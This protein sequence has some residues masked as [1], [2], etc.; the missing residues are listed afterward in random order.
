[1]FGKIKIW[2]GTCT[3]VPVN[4]MKKKT[5]YDYFITSE[6][7]VMVF[8]LC[9]STVE[10]QRN[11]SFLLLSSNLFVIFYYYSRTIFV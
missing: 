8:F 7:I 10:I 3:L 4:Y 2:I 9:I 5:E 1:M 11:G 6:D